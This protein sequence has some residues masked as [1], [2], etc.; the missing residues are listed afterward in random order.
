[1]ALD[2]VRK[3]AFEDDNAG[4]SIFAVVPLHGEACTITVSLDFRVRKTRVHPLIELPE[5]RTLRRQPTIRR[6][7]SWV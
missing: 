4:L 2:W 5:R 3:V 6:I 7:A 1:M